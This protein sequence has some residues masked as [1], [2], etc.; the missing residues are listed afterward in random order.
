M[1]PG[2]CGEPSTPGAEGARARH[3]GHRAAPRLARPADQAVTWMPS[4]GFITCTFTLGAMAATARRIVGVVHRHRLRYAHQLTGAGRVLGA[5]RVRSV[6]DAEEAQLGPVA[7][8]DQLH[9]AEEVG[10]AARVHPHSADLQDEAGRRVDGQRRVD[11]GHEI[12]GHVET[13][14]LELGHEPLAHEIALPYRLDRQAGG[15]EGLE[16]LEVVADVITVIVGEEH[17]HGLG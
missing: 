10:V 11:G 17:Q 13:G 3:V 15:V 9:V 14:V 12:H 6:A 16:H 2:E 4:P 1:S 8:A 7:L 5:H